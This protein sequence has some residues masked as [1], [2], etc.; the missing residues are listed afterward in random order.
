MKKHYNQLKATPLE[1][2]PEGKMMSTSMIDSLNVTVDPT[3]SVLF[4][5]P[6]GENNTEY[7]DITY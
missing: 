4:D 1:L 3:E 5:G 2:I 6:D 7:F